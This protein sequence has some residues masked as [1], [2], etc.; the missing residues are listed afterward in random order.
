MTRNSSHL[1]IKYRIVQTFDIWLG[2]IYCLTL[3]HKMNVIWI[4]EM[5]K[6]MP[7]SAHYVHLVSTSAEHGIFI[8][9]QFSEFYEDNEHNDIC[10]INVH[11]LARICL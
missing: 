1:Q 9:S 7:K 3:C 2:I 6:F 4:C 11:Y 10:A 5:C 8:M